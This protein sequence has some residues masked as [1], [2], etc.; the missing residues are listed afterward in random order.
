L[1]AAGR[2]FETYGLRFDRTR[3]W[4]L[5]GGGVLRLRLVAARND[6][7]SQR[8]E[9]QQA[10]GGTSRVLQSI[11]RL[12]LRA[13]SATSL[14][15]GASTRRAN[16]TAIAECISDTRLHQ[17]VSSDRTIFCAVVCRVPKG[18]KR[19]DRPS[20]SRSASAEEVL[21]DLE[22]VARR[23]AQELDARA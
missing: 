12:A 18:G 21:G 3:F 13:C 14:R 10:C 15:P 16:P 11:T 20:A 2:R 17:S 9:A 1:G 19:L 7:E 23:Q 5:V 22:T 4:R 8:S 6:E